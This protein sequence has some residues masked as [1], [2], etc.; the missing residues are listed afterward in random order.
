MVHGAKAM[1]AKMGVDLDGAVSVQANEVDCHWCVR[2]I[3]M[4][5]K[6][7][8]SFDKHKMRL[9]VANSQGLCLMLW[10]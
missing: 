8:G 5:Y 9:L 4:N 1:Q 6:A 7:D 3:K 2:I 10:N